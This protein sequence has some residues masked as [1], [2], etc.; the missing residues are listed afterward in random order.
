MSDLVPR[1][2]PRPII[3]LHGEV[4]DRTDT[5]RVV[6]LLDQLRQHKRDVDA[7]ISAC[8]EAIN[9]EMD[10]Q[11]KFTLQYGQ[12]RA[13]GSSADAARKYFYDT[14]VLRD[15]LREAGLPEDRIEELI[16]KTYQEHVSRRD[17]QR[18][19]KARPEY[20]KVI[21]EAERVIQKRRS[22]GIRVVKDAA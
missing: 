15:G 6:E 17:I 22:V 14:E 18:L 21:D 12:L 16:L 2:E 4:I 7:A 19:R 5:P 11:G 3:N 20:A 10:R 13:E 9:E 8:E 1:S